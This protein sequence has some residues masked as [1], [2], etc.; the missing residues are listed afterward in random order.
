MDKIIIFYFLKFLQ[1]ELVNQSVNA[2]L[3]RAKKSA[4]RS[5]RS[6]KRFRSL[7]IDAQTDGL[8]KLE[9]YNIIYESGK[10]DL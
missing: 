4:S 6:V 10:R 8:H 9:K 2:F 3:H 5:S 7:V 1:L